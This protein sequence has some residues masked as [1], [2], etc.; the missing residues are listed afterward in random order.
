MLNKKYLYSIV[1]II[2]ILLVAFYKL[3]DMKYQT[4]E[5][6]VTSSKVSKSKVGNKNEGLMS[7]TVT[8]D[9][10]KY[11]AHLLNN[12]AAKSFA[13]KL[14]VTLTFDSYAK[15][16]DEKIADLP[17]KLNTSNMPVGDSASKGEIG[18]WSPQP[19]IVLY[20]GNVSHYDGIHIIGKFDDVSAIKTIQKQTGKFQV[21][22]S[23]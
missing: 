19:R 6:V 16:V 5:Q 1:T 18:Y 17:V 23:K 22:I 11:R 7:V 9:N 21:S 10:K 2:I 20:Y 8:I 14:P 13:K 3:V 12:S 15:G 4:N